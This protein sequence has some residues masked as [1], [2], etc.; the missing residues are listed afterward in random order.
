MLRVHEIHNSNVQ[1]KGALIHSSSSQPN[2]T[3]CRK[4]VFPRRHKI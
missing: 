4:E 1:A 3:E 2:S